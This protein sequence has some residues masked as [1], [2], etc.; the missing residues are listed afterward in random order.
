MAWHDLVTCQSDEVETELNRALTFSLH[1][2]RKV[3]WP[4]FELLWAWWIESGACES[5]FVYVIT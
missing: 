5:I 3:A 1:H 2:P 4:N